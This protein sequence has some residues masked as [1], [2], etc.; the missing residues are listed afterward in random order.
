MCINNGSGKKEKKILQIN[1]RQDDN[2]KCECRVVM[3]KS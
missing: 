1:T 3:V 2:R